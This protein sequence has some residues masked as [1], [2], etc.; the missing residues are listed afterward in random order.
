M[1]I[2]LLSIALCHD[3]YMLMYVYVIFRLKKEK[4]RL[5]SYRLSS[6]DGARHAIRIHPEFRIFVLANRPGF[7]FLGRFSSLDIAS[8][9][10]KEL[11]TH[12]VSLVFIDVH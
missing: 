4:R 6:S 8:Q 5:I 12:S 2:Q 9:G 3:I 10:L 1:Y 11:T 7:P